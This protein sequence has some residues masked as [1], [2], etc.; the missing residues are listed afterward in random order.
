MNAT[1]KLLSRS[2]SF[3][4]FCVADVFEAA[5]V[6]AAWERKSGQQLTAI[7]RTPTLPTHNT[8]CQFRFVDL[9]KE[10]SFWTRPIEKA[11]IVLPILAAAHCIVNRFCTR[12]RRCPKSSGH[13]VV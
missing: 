7:P 3:E 12:I 8:T 4:I 6:C 1:P 9:I 5:L 2:A 10:S 13:A 11:I